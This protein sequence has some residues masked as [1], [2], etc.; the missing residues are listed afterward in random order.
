[1]EHI[2]LMDMAL[3]EMV[4]L[5]LLGTRDWVAMVMVGQ[6][7]RVFE[8]TEVLEATVVVFLGVLLVVLVVTRED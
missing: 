7:W 1:M 3:V 6:C 5:L 2:V 8:V 4:L